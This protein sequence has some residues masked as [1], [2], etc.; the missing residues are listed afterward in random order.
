MQIE[1]WENERNRCPVGKYITDIKDKKVQKKIL[2]AIDLLGEKGLL[3]IH[4]GYLLQINHKV[5]TLHELRIKY[6]NNIYRILLIV[7]NE[8]AW[9]L[10]AFTKKSN[11]T[12]PNEIE[13]AI[14]R[15][16]ILKLSLN[17]R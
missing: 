2:W 15:A 6:R 11:K 12:P 13:I 10:H 17:T 3:L 5:E 4:T 1:L 7:I 16:Q 14:E 8:A 9:L